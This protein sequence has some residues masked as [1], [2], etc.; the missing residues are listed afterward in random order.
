MYDNTVVMQNFPDQR[1]KIPVTTFSEKNKA[2]PSNSVKSLDFRTMHSVK[3][4]EKANIY[5]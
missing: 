4:D 5:P 2:V 3:D 1:Q